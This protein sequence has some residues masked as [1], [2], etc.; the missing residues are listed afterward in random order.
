MI[1]H[2]EHKF[3]NQKLHHGM[4]DK[5]LVNWLRPSGTKGPTRSFGLPDESVMVC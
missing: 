4:D 3:E 1:Q 2:S 5:D